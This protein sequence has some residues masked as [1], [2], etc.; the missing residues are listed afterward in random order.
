MK[1]KIEL[2][3]RWNQLQRICSNKNGMNMITYIP[4]LDVVI[5]G[6]YIAHSL[7]Q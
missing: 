1:W 6:V 3:Q 2:Q 4:I 7:A 5:K